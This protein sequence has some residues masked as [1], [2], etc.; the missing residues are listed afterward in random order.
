MPA[1]KLTKADYICRRLKAARELQGLS[2]EE[3]AK[4]CGVTPR[5]VERW[6]T[7]YY[8]INVGQFESLCKLLHVTPNDILMEE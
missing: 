5:T 3:I 1:K 7:M 2:N 8:T 4:R 6:L